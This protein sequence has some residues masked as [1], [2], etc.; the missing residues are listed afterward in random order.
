VDHHVESP[1]SSPKGATAAVT[2]EATAASGQPEADAASEQVSL[3]G[4]HDDT[5]QQ[6]IHGPVPLPSDVGA[7]NGSQAAPAAETAAD[8]GQ[9]AD[10]GSEA[11]T[12][13]A[14]EAGVHP[15]AG[16]A[17][18]E[19]GAADPDA[20]ADPISYSQDGAFSF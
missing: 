5:E 9:E 10:V 13:P 6:L 7:L 19:A 18:P 16:A 11:G 4:T 15:A 1:S 14:P 20:D 2:E 12:G 8:V 17:D 3:N